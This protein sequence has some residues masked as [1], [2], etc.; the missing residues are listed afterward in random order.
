VASSHV[1][2]LIRTYPVTVTSYVWHISVVE[3]TRRTNPGTVTCFVWQIS[4]V[5]CT[6]RTYPG[7]VTSFVWQILVVEC[8]RR[9]KTHVYRQTSAV[10]CSA[11][12]K[13]FE[14]TGM[15]SIPVHITSDLNCG[16]GT[17]RLIR[18]LSKM[19]GELPYPM[20]AN[21]HILR[22]DT[23]IYTWVHACM[24][25]CVR[26]YVYV[27]YAYMEAWDCDYASDLFCDAWIAAWSCADQGL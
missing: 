24:S 26:L 5:E 23:K 9:K 21:A 2:K 10:Q 11:S 13:N 17:C 3:C 20:L 8:T 22:W 19:R 16:H 27:I 12:G 7:T 18:D 4:V 14:T 6:R 25:L 1:H 15:V